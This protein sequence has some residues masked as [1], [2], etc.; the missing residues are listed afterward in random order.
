M[1]PEL[2]DK[3][4]LVGKYMGV[5]HLQLF[6]WEGAEPMGVHICEDEY[7]NFDYGNIIFYNP[8][9][10]WNTLMPVCKKIIESYFDMRGDIYLGLQK[11]DINATFEAVV[12]FIKF[13]NDDSKPKLT[14]NK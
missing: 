2:I 4:M 10:D 5:E 11:C 12:E 7:G 1:K 14:W 3:I 8:H 6:Y 13:W 9:S